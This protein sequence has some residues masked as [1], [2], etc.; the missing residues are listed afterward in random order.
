MVAVPPATPVTV[1]EPEPM[2]ATLVLSLLHVP[3][4]VT[5]ASVVVVPTQTPD[6]PPVIAAGAALTVTVNE[7]ADE[8]QPATVFTALTTL[9]VVVVTVWLK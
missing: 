6:V 8:E 3:E 7:V 1:P 2:V 4:G 5:S 9:V